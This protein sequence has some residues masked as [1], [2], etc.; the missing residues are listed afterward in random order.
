VQTLNNQYTILQNQD[1]NTSPMEWDKFKKILIILAHPDDPEFFCGATIAYWAEKGH[2]ISYC[3]LT[4]GEKGGN[5]QLKSEDL[6]KIRKS[7]QLL[8]AKVLGVEEVRFLDYP[9]GFIIPDIELRK[10][11]VRVIRAQKADVLVTSDPTNYFPRP[12][13]INHPDHRATGQVVMDATFPAA[14]NA[15]YFPDLIAEGL[16]PHA[17]EELWL[18]NPSQPDTIIDITR[19]WEKKLQALYEHRSQIGDRQ[20]FDEKMLRRRSQGSTIENPR[21]EEK[22]R[23]IIF[24]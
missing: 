8:A 2:H 13:Y 5:Y 16:S 11:I 22:F 14:G 21:Y 4:N 1:I 15:H 7:E 19:W 23:R 18:S 6:S 24:L 20:E 9:D 10:T 3:L 12:G 17:P